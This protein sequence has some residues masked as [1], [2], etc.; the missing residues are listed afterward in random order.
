[1]K[2]KA[3]VILHL[4]Q[5]I[6]DATF[7]RITAESIKPSDRIMADLGLDSLDYATVMLGCEQWCG[8]K[9]NE[10]KVNWAEIDTVEKLA[11]LFAATSQS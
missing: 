7:G 4:S 9:L 3:Q 8:V 10:N 1:M 5:A 11:D 2:S 6:A